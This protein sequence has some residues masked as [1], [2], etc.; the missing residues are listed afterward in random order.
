M[1]QD[2]IRTE[3]A[4]HDALRSLLR[5]AAENGVT[6]EGGWPVEWTESDGGWDV[7]I[8]ELADE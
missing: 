6:V 8:V 3:E 2:T 7:E 4:F 5:E 1:D